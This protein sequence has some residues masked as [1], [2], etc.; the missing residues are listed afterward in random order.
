MR[1]GGLPD[2]ALFADAEVTD[3]FGNTARLLYRLAHVVD[4]HAIDIRA[5]LF[6]ISCP[7]RGMHV[8]PGVG[9]GK[10]SVGD[11]IRHDL[12]FR[13]VNRRFAVQ[14]SLKRKN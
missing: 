7:I 11:A 6:L 5:S 4:H 12:G 10:T 3:R 1:R 13:F 9:G 14:L 8:A 2:L